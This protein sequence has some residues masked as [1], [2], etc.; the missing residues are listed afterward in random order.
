MLEGY[1]TLIEIVEVSQSETKERTIEKL[2]LSKG[3]Y[4]EHIYNYTDALKTYQRAAWY[5]S[6][7]DPTPKV[8]LKIAKCHLKLKNNK[9]AT[10][11]Y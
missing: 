8:Y 7:I 11:A 10:I 1:D 9:R 4:L 5:Q 2:L 3:R 6:T